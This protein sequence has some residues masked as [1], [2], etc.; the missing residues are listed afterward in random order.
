MQHQWLT[1]Y[2]V[3]FWPRDRVVDVVHGTGTVTG[4]LRDVGVYVRFDGT[5]ED[6]LMAPRN[7]RKL[8]VPS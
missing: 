1:F 6:R 8:E 5:T 7:I 2:R 3:R 4:L